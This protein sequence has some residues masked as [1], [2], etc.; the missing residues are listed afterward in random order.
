M[1]RIPYIILNRMTTEKLK[2]LEKLLS[3]HFFL[4]F[5][6][7]KRILEMKMANNWNL[8]GSSFPVNNQRFIL[9]NWT[10]E[11]FCCYTHLNENKLHHSLSINVGLRKILL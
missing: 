8:L 1:L 11:F 5:Y 4:I 10:I 9:N 2:S 6:L 3:D 7:I